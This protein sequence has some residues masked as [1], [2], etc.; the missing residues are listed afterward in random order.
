MG[1]S[2]SQLT[3]FTIAVHL[4]V[5]FLLFHTNRPTS[6]PNCACLRYSDLQVL[7]NDHRFVFSQSERKKF[8]CF[9]FVVQKKNSCPF[10][11]LGFWLVAYV[12]AHLPSSF[13]WKSTHYVFLCFSAK[14]MTVDIIKFRMCLTDMRSSK[15]CPRCRANARYLS[16]LNS[17]HSVQGL[18]D[19]LE[20][21]F[22]VIGVICIL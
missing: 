17:W 4:N 7:L 11:L 9:S 18:N 15:T 14:L 20:Q 21:W 22:K 12:R 16:A 10:R 8:T 1:A 2:R 19:A 5:F 13:N 3:V 6:L